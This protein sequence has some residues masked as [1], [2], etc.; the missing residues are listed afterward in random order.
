MIMMQL[1]IERIYTKPVDLDGYRILVDRLWPRGISKV[2]AHLDWW[3]KQVGPS[4]ELR[5]WFGHDPAKY[6][7]FKQRYLA[8]LADNPALTE[9]KEK[10]TA[11]LATT[12]V[13]LL[14]GAKDEQHNQAVILKELLDKQLG[15][16]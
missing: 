14:Y 10:V 2:N 6:D 4:N 9:L 1:K 16:H 7:E 8:E 15:N 5:K 11:Q 13:I 12:N 3:A